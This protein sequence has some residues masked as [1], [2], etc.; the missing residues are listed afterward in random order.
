MF[1]CPL[2][3]EFRESDKAA[4]LRGANFDTIET[5]IVIVLKTGDRLITTSPDS[6]FCLLLF[7]RGLFAG[8]H[9]ELWQKNSV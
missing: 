7:T 3:R 9:D 6:V 5:L 1:A 4:K 8:Y 2:C